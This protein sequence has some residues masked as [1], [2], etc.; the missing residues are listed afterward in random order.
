MTQETPYQSGMRQ[1]SE[2]TS[3]GLFDQLAPQAVDEA[4]AAKFRLGIRILNIGRDGRFK[5]ELRRA[6]RPD[7]RS[8]H[9]AHADLGPGRL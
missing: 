8:P 4:P 6:A 7:R 3:M 9:E 2:N 1:A 5:H